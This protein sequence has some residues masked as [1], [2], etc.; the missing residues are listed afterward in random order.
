[1]APFSSGFRDQ[2]VQ[3]ESNLP[4]LWYWVKS[5]DSQKH[6]FSKAPIQK[7]HFPWLN[8][9]RI[10]TPTNKNLTFAWRVSIV[11]YDI[12]IFR[13]LRTKD[14]ENIEKP[15]PSSQNAD[16]TWECTAASF[17]EF[18]GQVPKKED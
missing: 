11:A 9:V 1:M 17:W 15:A 7:C 16:E 13:K 18:F 10:K 12:W 8:F 2:G 3:K 14:P 5:A 6:R 4:F